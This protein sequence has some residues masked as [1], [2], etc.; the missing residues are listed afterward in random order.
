MVT[1]VCFLRRKAGL[2]DEEFHAHWRDRH[3]PLVRDTGAGTRL[4]R[5]YRQLHR[6][7]G[8][9]T[10]SPGVDGVAVLEFESVDDYWAYVASDDYRDVVAPDEDRF[11]DRDGLVWLLAEG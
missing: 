1:L 9:L 3:G 7:P 11:L 2:T 5:S 10:G 4:I 8:D 6:L